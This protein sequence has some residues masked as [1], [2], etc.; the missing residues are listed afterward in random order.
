MI[1]MD[2]PFATAASRRLV[3]SALPNA[4]VVDD[5]P[6]PTGPPAPPARSRRLLARALRSLADRLDPR[7]CAEAPP[8]PYAR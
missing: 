6:P 3:H 5:E 2:G 7:T 1:P 8:A 4:P